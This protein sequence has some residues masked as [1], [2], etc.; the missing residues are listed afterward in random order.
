[1]SFARRISAAPVLRLAAFAAF[2]V[3]AAFAAS[4]A[5]AAAGRAR[6][7]VDSVQRVL[8]RYVAALGGRAAVTAVRSTHLVGRLSAFGLTGTTQGW[9][10]RPDRSA[11]ET[12]LGP[13]TLL[14]GFDGTAGWRTDPSGKVTVLEGHGLE[15]ARASAWMENDRYLDPDRGG[16]TVTYVGAEKDSS[17]SYDVLEITPPG[18][19]PRRFWFDVTQGLPVREVAQDDQQTLMTTMS[20]WRPVAGRKIAFHTSTRVVGMPANSITI[21]LDS[22]E[23]NVAVDPAR[24]TPPAAPAGAV[25]WLKQDGS[26]RLPFLYSGRHVWLRAS[27]NGA[28]PAD[29]L[30]DTGA[31]ITVIDSAYAAQMGLVTEG[32]MNAMGA[33]SSGAATFAKLKTLRVVSDDGDGVELADQ[34][35]GVLSV[36]GILAP[37][38]WRDCA[39]VLGYSFI[40]QFVT[41]IDYDH[42]VL[43]LRDP[44]SFKY[45]GKGHKLA[46]S[47]AG[48]VPVVRMKL[49]GSIEGDFR[50][51]V[52]SNS[53]VDVHGPFVKAHRLDRVGGRKIPSSGAGFGGTFTSQ[54]TRLDRIDIGPYGW[55][56]PVVALSGATT[57]ALASIDYA[58]NA[59]NQLLE[60]FK[61][62]L[63]YDHH[64]VYL[65]PGAKYAAPDRFSRAGLLLL[66]LGD[67]VTAG[68]VLKGSPAE[69]AGVREGDTVTAVEGKPILSYRMDEV[70]S[71]FEEG[72]NGRAVKIDLRRDGKAITVTLKLRDML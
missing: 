61:C 1:M 55:D 9:S 46:M 20:D 12:H 38:F 2:S 23:V 6:D 45:E 67:T 60:R 36:N 44:A 35:V 18:G 72:E 16:G 68:Q 14:E 48:T 11:S 7:G 42:A 10:E 34:K 24:Y 29:F 71:L 27:I 41:E 54:I 57:G 4:P 33:G 47:L 50:L 37:F 28:P 58:G 26:A 63:D 64:A 31:S 62:T 59:G 40:S 5:A 39:G 53:T 19:H 8:D 49:N 17:G 30:F 56:H 15:K 3:A 66:K 65:E 25:K 32:K 70:A 43:V 51:D 21:D 69:R 52:G 13:F 22:V